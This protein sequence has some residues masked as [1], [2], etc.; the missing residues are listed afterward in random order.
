[1]HS[2]GLQIPFSFLFGA[3]IDANMHLLRLGFTPESISGLLG[4][5]STAY[6]VQMGF[7]LVGIG[8]QSVGLVLE[9]RPQVTMMSAEAFVRLLSHHAQRL[10][11]F[12]F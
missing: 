12:L 4:T 11:K 1:M 5:D 10:D 2:V 9:V 6:L 3:F 8:I 7:L